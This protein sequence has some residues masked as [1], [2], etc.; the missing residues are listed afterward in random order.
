MATEESKI[1]LLQSIR[2]VLE[3]LILVGVCWLA[4]SATEGA[5]AIA[6]LESQ[7]KGIEDQVQLVRLEVS[8]VQTLGQQIAQDDIRIKD[9]E[10][11]ATALETERHK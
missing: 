11:R 2:T 7:L 9:L 5:K 6:V 8:S 1:T 4:Y 3:S 10:R